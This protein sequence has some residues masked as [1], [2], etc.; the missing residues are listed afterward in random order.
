MDIERKFGIRI[1]NLLRVKKNNKSLKFDNLTMVPIDK[2]LINKKI[3]RK[4][5]VDWINDYHGNVF[6]KL[7]GFMNRS[8]L[9]ELKKACSN[10]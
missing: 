7:K 6:Q 2:S 4:D 9:I 3:L 1:E 10:I 8:E 5:E